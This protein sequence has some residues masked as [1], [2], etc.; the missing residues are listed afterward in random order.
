METQWGVLP[1]SSG[2]VAVW[3]AEME[4]RKEGQVLYLAISRVY[5]FLV[6]SIL[7]PKKKVSTHETSLN[8]ISLQP[9]GLISASSGKIYQLVCFFSTCLLWCPQQPQPTFLTVILWCVREEE[10]T[11]WE[12]SAPGNASLFLQMSGICIFSST[13]RHNWISSCPS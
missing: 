4:G 12:K 3:K 9:R 11:I 7:V 13:F 8:W 1:C 5:Y 10:N 2:R 6:C